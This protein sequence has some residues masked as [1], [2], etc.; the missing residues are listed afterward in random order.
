MSAEL[1]KALDIDGEQYRI[2]KLDAVTALKVARLVMTKILPVL[3]MP[4]IT[5]VMSLTNVEDIFDKLDFD[6][7]ASAL[8]KITDE[9]IDRLVKLSLRSCF[10]TMPAGDAP[11]IND[12]GSWGVPEVEYDLVLMV[13]L[14]VETVSFG[15]SAFFAGNPLGSLPGG[16]TSF[17]PGQ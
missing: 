17:Q 9:D 7:I 15:L 11:V 8:D 10:K 6:S 12:N 14:V 2:K 1:W 4:G 13:R 5:D 16:L 3:D